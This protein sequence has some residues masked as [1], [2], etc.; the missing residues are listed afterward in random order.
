M[1]CSKKQLKA[2]KD[3][4]RRMS[5]KAKLVQPEPHPEPLKD[6]VSHAAPG[7]FNRLLRS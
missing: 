6:K 3:A 1:F 2:I 4:H 7:I 5:E